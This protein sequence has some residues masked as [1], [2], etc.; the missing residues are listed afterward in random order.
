[1]RRLVIIPTYNERENIEAMVAKVFSLA[2]NY[3]LLVVDDGSP[4]G[5]A[6]VVRETME[7]KI[8]HAPRGENGFGYDPIFYIDGRSFAEFSAEEKNAV[9]HRKRA[10]EQ[11]VAELKKRME[12]RK[13]NEN[14]D[15]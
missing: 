6:E 3:S 10:L 12:E 1:M 13:K 9:S 15:E 8:G 11:V 5:T 2:G 4:D 7:G 14:V